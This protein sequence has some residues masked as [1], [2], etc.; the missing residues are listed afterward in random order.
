MSMTIGKRVVLGFASITLIAAVLGA[1]ALLELTKIGRISLGIANDALPGTALSGEIAMMT[2]QNRGLLLEHVIADNEKQFADVEERITDTRT[3]LDDVVK[4]Y[5]ATITLDA[6]RQLFA[7]VTAARADWSATREA[8]MSLSRA[9]KPKEAMEAY[10]NKA[11]PAFRKMRT[12]VAA[13]SEFNQKN[14]EAMG[15]ATQASVNSGKTG[16]SI[17]IGCAIAISVLLGVLIVRSVN[18]VLNRIANTL[19][20][21]SAQVAAASGQVAAGSQSLAQGA[22]EQAAALEESTSALEEMA[23]MTKKNA[24]TAQQARALAT[25]T[26]AAAAKGNEAMVKM[27]AAISDIQKSA[28]ET[29]KILKTID[30]IAFQT[31]LLALNA[32]VEAARAGEA[33]KGFAVVAEEV[34]NL[35]MRSAEAAKSTATMIEG[36]VQN[37]RN[38]VS[39]VTEVGRTLEEITSASLKV[40][41]LVGELA[42]AGLE[43]SQ[44]IGQINTAV[45]QMDKVTQE[46]AAN[47]EESA[48]AA[49]ELSSQAEQMQGVV[50]ELIALV[51]GTAPAARGETAAKRTTAPVATATVRK[52]PVR[53]KPKSSHTNAEAAI[54]FGEEDGDF[55]EFSKAA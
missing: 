35:A 53:I 2:E 46:S 11:Y 8:V 37:A 20:E 17:G 23:S 3:R 39:I 54:P 9:M 33:G 48:A 45:S 16:V 43:Q 18:K 25:D 36:S 1:F 30:E 27:S 6:D 40:N 29:S 38:G 14:G 55:K 5:E 47:A 32:A 26:Q 41:N 51:G 4:R 12:A 19:G 10:T 21:G 31:N 22:S 34:R 15:V 28:T 52:T 13:M 7:T 49:E 24:D 42:A 50:G 44:G